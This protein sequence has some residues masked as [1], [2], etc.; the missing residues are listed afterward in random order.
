MRNKNII[1]YV[2]VTAASI[3]ALPLSSFSQ[4]KESPNI[5]YILA[6][7]L[8]YG[9]LGC[10]GQE[11]IKTPNIDR[12]AKQGLRFTQHYSG[13]TVSAPS[14][15]SL[16]TGLHTG[17]TPIRGNQE[18]YPEGQEAM[19]ANTYT[20][21][22]FLKDAGYETGAFGKW[23]LGYPGSASEPSKLGFDEFYGYNCQR[24]SHNYYPYYIWHNDQKVML[25]GNTGDNQTQYAQDMIQGE[26]LKFIESNKDNKFFAYIPYLLP[27][28]ELLVPDD[29][30]LAMYKGKLE[31]GKPYNGPKRAADSK[32]FKINAY[33]YVED[34][35]ANFAAMVARLDMYVGQVLDLLE[36]LG[37]AD[38]TIVMFAS[39]N[40]SHR[41][42]GHNPAFFN[43]SGGLRG[44]K[45]DLYEGGIRVPLIV[46]WPKHIKEGATTDHVSAMW[47][48]MPTLSDI[49]G[50]KTK[51]EGDGVSFYPTLIGKKQ[52][53]HKYLYWEFHEYGGRVAV[54]YG[55]W[56]G[57]KY[58]YGKSPD[59]PMELYNLKDDVQ[60]KNNVAAENPKIVAK[61]EAFIKKS[62]TESE[63]F[64][65][66]RER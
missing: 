3:A 54:R 20:F 46:Q 64:N 34:P 11:I 22:H 51:I 4:E 21:V 61:I 25:P 66:G 10:Y 15:S 44:N 40:G 63:I 23:G 37:I 50:Q 41:E 16:L 39:D 65:F 47:D 62:R 2:G 31:P 60:E 6:D 59:A 26:A 12:M 28:A 5:I 29:D 24:I 1:K 38:N 14:R 36:E 9:D 18:V 33:G 48:M 13:S 32:G 45:R 52:K 8:G 57:V 17:H 53:E 58:N 35:H 27:H 42:G 56:K 7:D 30:I 49:V 19:P 55:D 43:S